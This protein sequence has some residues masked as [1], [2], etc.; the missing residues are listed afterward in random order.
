MP[1]QGWVRG[2]ET[3]SA[4]KFV[5]FGPKLPKSLKN[6]ALRALRMVKFVIEIANR[7]PVMPLVREIE[8]HAK[9]TDSKSDFLTRKWLKKTPKNLKIGSETTA[10]SKILFS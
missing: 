8:D 4:R 3:T 5:I 7:P 2:R 9:T 1:K 6:R 10:S